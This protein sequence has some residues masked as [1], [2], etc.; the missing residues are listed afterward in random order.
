MRYELSDYEGTTIKP[1]LPNKVRGRV[2]LDRVLLL[3]CRND[4]EQ[5]VSERTQSSKTSRARAAA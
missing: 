5:L 2:R 3:A 4:F 1:M